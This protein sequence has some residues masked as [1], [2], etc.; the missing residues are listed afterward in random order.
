MMKDIYYMAI[1][2]AVLTIVAIGIYIS[3]SKKDS[4]DHFNITTDPVVDKSPYKVLENTATCPNRPAVQNH[5]QYGGLNPKSN[6]NLTLTDFIN[7]YGT[8]ENYNS[9]DT[10]DVTSRRYCNLL[11]GV[12]NEYFNDRWNSLSECELTI[13]SECEELFP[14]APKKSYFGSV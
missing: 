12:N 8:G 9:Y 4:V 7:T 11:Y 13:K 3:T 10:A 6:A 1:A 14:N 5:T 2:V